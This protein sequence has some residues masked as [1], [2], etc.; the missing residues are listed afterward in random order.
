MRIALLSPEYPPKWGGIG[1][2]VYNLS[3]AFSRLGHEVH[4]ITRIEKVKRREIW[5]ERVRLHEV[6]WTYAPILFSTSYGKNAVVKLSEIANGFDVVCVQ[7]PYASVPEEYLGRIES[8]LVS[9]MHGTWKGER[10]ALSVGMSLMQ[11]HTDLATLLTSRFL[12]KY[13]RL[14][15]VKSQ[16]VV[17]VSQYC[18]SELLRYGLAECEL[19]RKLHVIPNGVDTS[20]FRPLD[21]SHAK[22]T[23]RA[24]YRIAPD[25]KM[26]LFVGRLVARKGVG[27][28]LKALAIAGSSD[29]GL[30]LKLVIVGTG[31]L[32]YSLR[33]VAGKLKVGGRVSFAQALD[34]KQL[35][36]HY[37]AAD[38]FI[39]PSFYEGFGIVMLEAMACGLP[40]VAS[41]VSAIPEVIVEGKTGRLVDPG[42]PA[43]LS[44]V[45]IDL[46][47]RPAL[48]AEMGR[49]AR[50]LV[51]SR[52]DWRTIAKKTEAVLQRVIS[53]IS[54]S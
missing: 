51:A 52:Y 36:Q 49:T 8:P 48:R 31:P 5:D 21:D 39:L 29:E 20:I 28:L 53:G 32:E 33:A 11:S 25:D 3:K 44:Q 12:E 13:E 30:K 1:T 35:V 50:A 38:L 34:L 42:D 4:V 37:N 47:S 7:C 17:A 16:A 14:A 2:Y 41:N 15:M 24:K 26:V 9:V 18:A 23:L 27:I 19:E 40:V 45:I 46:L 6:P 10:R 22:Q 54:Y 43:K